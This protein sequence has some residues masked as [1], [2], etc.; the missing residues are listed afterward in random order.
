VPYADKSNVRRWAH[1]NG[2]DLRCRGNIWFIPYQTIQNRTVER[3][4]PATFPEQL[5]MNCIKIH[6]C[7]RE[8][9]VLDPFV[10]M[11]HAGIAAK[12]C[13]IRKFI[14]FDIDPKYVDLAKEELE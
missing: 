9:V 10:G 5:A 8:L 12:K 11:G 2:Q 1:A 4:H 6:G 13:G 3:P 14:G 7:N